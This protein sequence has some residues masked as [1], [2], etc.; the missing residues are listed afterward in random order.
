MKSDPLGPPKIPVP[1]PRRRAAA[2][3]NKGASANRRPTLQAT[4]MDN[5]N[6]SIAVN[7]HRPAVAELRRWAA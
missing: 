5:V 2:S 1:T 4:I 7:A 3:F 6:H